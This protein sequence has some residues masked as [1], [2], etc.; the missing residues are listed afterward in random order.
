MNT[1]IIDQNRRYMWV[2]TET[3]FSTPHHEI[4]QT[5]LDNGFNGAVVLPSTYIEWYYPTVLFPQ[6]DER[7]DGQHVLPH[8]IGA[9]NFYGLDVFNWFCVGKW[10]RFRAYLGAM[11]PEWN[12]RLDQDVGI[13]DDWLNLTRPDVREAVADVAS[14]ALNIMPG[15]TGILMDYIRWPS[16][17]EELHHHITRTV[18]GVSGMMKALY[19]DKELLATCFRGHSPT[20]KPPYRNVGQYWPDW[21]EDKLIDR[22]FVT[23][24]KNA[25]EMHINLAGMPSDERISIKI[26][27][28]GD[29]GGLVSE[30]EFREMFKIV[31]EARFFRPGVWHYGLMKEVYWRVCRDIM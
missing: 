15:L 9:A 5:L 6:S 14:E 31:E 24:Y 4:C 25:D 16:G 18:L 21:L 8:F 29:G 26:R 2:R 23:L 28:T 22:V 3:L 11:T 13:D 12:V 27:P 20:G 7:I 19:P 1:S 10:E 30:V 17:N